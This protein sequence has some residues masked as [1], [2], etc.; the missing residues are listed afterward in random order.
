MKYRT[1]VDN[2]IFII[3]TFLVLYPFIE[4][5]TDPDYFNRKVIEYI[6]AQKI[7]ATMHRRTFEYAN[8]FEDFLKMIQKTHDIEMLKGIRYNIVTEIMQAT[9]HQNLYRS[10]GLDPDIDKTSGNPTGINKSNINAAKKLRRYINQ[11]TFAK[12]ECEKRLTSL[13]WDLGFQFQDDSKKV[14]RIS[15]NFCFF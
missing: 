7:A 12:K 9:A 15:K 2:Y 10:K 6:E 1:F 11:L 4:N 13:G 5:I 14:C 3:F 8:S